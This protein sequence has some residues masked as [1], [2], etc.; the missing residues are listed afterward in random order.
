MT[1]TKI[2]IVD[3]VAESGLTKKEAIDSIEALL[4]IMKN[5]L[6]G[7]EDIL[8]SGFGK[9]CVKDKS[10]RRGRNPVSGESL[11]LDKRRVVTFKCSSVLRKKIN[12]GL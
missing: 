2:H 6:G 1:L 11:I 5:T 3:K 7:G 12:Q 9:F 4:D 8:F 10:Q